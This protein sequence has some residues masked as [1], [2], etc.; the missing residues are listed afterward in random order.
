MVQ[1]LACLF[2]SVAVMFVE[3]CEDSF[4][5]ACRHTLQQNEGNQLLAFSVASHLVTYVL[6]RPAF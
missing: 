4:L 3:I 2:R 1:L 6:A 5:Y